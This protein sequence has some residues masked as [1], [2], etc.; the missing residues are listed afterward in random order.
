VLGVLK[1]GDRR[2]ARLVFPM[3]RDVKARSRLHFSK[4]SDGT[5]GD[6]SLLKNTKALRLSGRRDGYLGVQ[7]RLMS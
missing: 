7:S 1:K 4:V 2:L 5:E 3:E 6:S